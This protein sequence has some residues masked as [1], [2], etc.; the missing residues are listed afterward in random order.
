MT[1][2]RTIRTQTD[3]RIRQIETLYPRQFCFITS[4]QRLLRSY[5]DT[6]DTSCGLRRTAAVY[7]AA[8]S[9]LANPASEGLRQILATLVPEI[10]KMNSKVKKKMSIWH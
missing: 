10:L 7:L 8:F 3:I 2:T 4:S 9:P 6:A 1:R 5:G